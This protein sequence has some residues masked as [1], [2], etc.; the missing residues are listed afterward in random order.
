MFRGRKRKL[1]THYI[2]EPYYHGSDSSDISGHEEDAPD[3]RVR[4]VPGEEG[5]HDDRDVH[6]NLEEDQDLG[7]NGVHAV[8]E[9]QE[10]LH[11]HQDLHQ[12]DAQL[13]LPEQPQQLQLRGQQDPPPPTPPLPG[14]QHEQDLHDT[15]DEHQPRQDSPVASQEDYMDYGVDI[16]EEDDE[17]D[18]DFSDLDEDD[19]QEADDIVQQDY[20]SLLETLSEKWISAK[21]EHNISKVGTNALWKIGFNLIPKLLEAKNL[22]RITKKTPQFNHIRRLLHKKKRLMLKWRWHI[23]TETLT[24]L[25]SSRIQSLQIQ[26]SQP[27]NMKKCTR[28]PL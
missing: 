7:E 20:A 11:L 10:Q 1:P 22:E 9:P 28:R 13:P 2:P 18:D 15:P 3:R 8:Q 25:Q 14:Q 23:G 6:D 27:M 5:V 21:M 16:E 4:V 17:Q 24:K 12:Q 26:N 19:D